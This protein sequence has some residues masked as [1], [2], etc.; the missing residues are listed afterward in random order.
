[1]RVRLLYN[2][3][4]MRLQ[5]I[6]LR[7][8]LELT[9]LKIRLVGHRMKNKLQVINL[10]PSHRGRL[11]I[12]NSKHR[13]QVASL[14]NKGCLTVPGSK[15]LEVNLRMLRSKFLKSRIVSVRLREIP[16]KH[17]VLLIVWKNRV[18]VNNLRSRVI[19]LRAKVPIVLTCRV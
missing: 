16:L 12:M 1:M 18:L 10:R 8:K 15:C 7:V 11:Q 5:I 19:V 9:V 2:A 17:R 4:R 14:K 3:P 13:I 6:M